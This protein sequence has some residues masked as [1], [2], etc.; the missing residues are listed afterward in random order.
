MTAEERVQRLEGLI[1]L[2]DGVVWETD[3]ETLISTYV[4]SR[5]ESMLGYTPSEWMGDPMFWEAHLHPDT[6]VRMR[7]ERAAFMAVGQPFRQE[8]RLLSR[9]GAAVWV[10]DV[11][12]PVMQDGRLTAL[13]GV[14]FDITAQREAAFL[15]V[16]LKDRLSKIFEATPVGITI[17]VAATGEL[18]DVNP[19]FEALTGYG[20]ADLVGHT[21]LSLGVWPKAEDQQQLI[22]ELEDQ[23]T[24]RDRQV[25]LCRR[26]GELFEALVTYER[27]E[28]NALPC[29]L[30][31]TQD[32]SERQQAEAQVRQAERRFRGLVQNSADMFTVLDEEGH[33]VYVSPAVKR[34][35]N[36]EPEEVMGLHVSQHVHRDD[37]PAVQADL[38]ALKRTPE[39]VRV[40]TYRQRD[41][42]GQWLWV[43]TTT[44]TQLHD[45]AVRGIV[46]NTRD[47]TER[48]ESEVRLAASEGRFRSLVQNASDLITVVD[49]Q[50]VVMYESPSVLTLLDRRPEDLVGRP[51]FGT[52]D[53]ADHAQIRGVV[54]RTVA[55]G[56][57]HVERT[58]FR[59]VRQDGTVRWMEG[60]ATNLLGDPYIG[61]VVINSRDVTDRTLAEDALRTSQ[62]TFQALFEH[63]PDGI[64]LIEFDGEMPIVQCN[65]VAA[66]MNGYTPEELIGHSTHVMLPDADRA[67]AEASGS[68]DFQA[69]VQAQRHTELS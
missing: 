44:S 67:R 63:S 25:T 38:D 10:R 52:V 12:T 47:V 16:S 26:S 54:A 37:W 55:G 9:S 27:L 29:L 57:G 24:L 62:Q 11:S 21:L 39:D 60:A 43:E 49:S 28:I 33:Y 13:G 36:V 31:I 1:D 17:S 30:A 6:V 61:E 59:A 2:I 65:Q 20:R 46:C 23:Q 42:R 5:L 3:P 56:E 69:T 35:Y 14:M 64:L 40:S 22:T 15:S 34:L 48:R 50:G 7:T 32:I 41:S 19:A 68:A 53:P 4:S 8:Y 51:V 18:L 45:P 58:T 66:A